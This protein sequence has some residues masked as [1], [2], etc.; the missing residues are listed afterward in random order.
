MIVLKGSFAEIN[1]GCPKPGGSLLYL[2]LNLPYNCNY[3]C[4]K[5]CNV[6]DSQSVPSHSSHLRQEVLRTLISS[7]STAGIKVLVVAG[8]G[9]PLMDPMFREVI[10]LSTRA[11]LIPY[12]FTNGSLL[13]PI[14]VQ[15]LAEHRAS[16]IIS[17][18]SLDATR[19]NRLT[20]GHGNLPHVLENIANC[21]EVYAG[22]IESHDGS[23]LG[24]LAINMVVNTINCDEVERLR[25]FCEEDIVF[26]CNQPTRIGQAEIN[27][28]TLYGETPS[29]AEVDKIMSVVSRRQQPLGTTSD[30]QW[31]AYMRNGV[32][33]SPSG[34]VLTCAYA[35]ETEG[36]YQPLSLNSLTATNTEVMASVERFYQ[37]HGHSRCILRH[38]KYRE[39]LSFLRTRR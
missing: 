22:L 11:G 9:E 4:L 34:Q 19:Y 7:A 17:L 31:C 20:G 27:W 28:S 23:R 8:E 12:V 24:S 25:Q 13:D 29:N 18:D 14:S 30:G 35:I 2:M 3:R 36:L 26:V 37:E 39:F 21:R 15:F 32:S 10:E 16:L 1:I 38:P 33:I 5:C 6:L